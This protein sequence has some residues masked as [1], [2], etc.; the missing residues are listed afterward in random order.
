VV[1]QV[2]LEVVFLC[3]GLGAQLAG[4]R[5]DSGMQSH[6]KC[7]VTSVGESFATHAASERLLTSV[8]AQVL[9]KQHLA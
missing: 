9:F 7:H 2:G 5:L 1:V 6:V 8:D 4:V 3:E